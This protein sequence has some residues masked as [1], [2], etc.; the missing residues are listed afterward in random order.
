MK[1]EAGYS[2]ANTGNGH[3]QPLELEKTTK[4][5]PVSLQKECGPADTLTSDFGLRTRTE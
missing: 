1:T 3:Q 2:D 5:S 4:D